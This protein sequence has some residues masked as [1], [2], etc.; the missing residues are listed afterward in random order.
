MFGRMRACC[1]AV[2]ICFMVS[3]GAQA[4]VL[5]FTYE[6]SVEF[7]GGYPPDG[8][9]PWLTATF[10]DG[11]TPGSVNLL[12]E[13][14]NLTDPEFVASWLFNINPDLE[15]YI[16]DLD[17]IEVDR[18]GNFDD[19]T[20][21]TAANTYQANGDGLFDINVEFES[22][23]GGTFNWF[24]AGESLEYRIEGIPSLTAASFDY[25][26]H[27]DGGQGEFPTAAHVGNTGPGD[28]YSG[29][30]TVPEPATLALLALGGL[31]VS[32]RRR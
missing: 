25:L 30:V 21:Y 31:L 3:S 23:T 5:S 17:F 8:A 1:L 14:T 32:R 7:S 18:Y 10:D 15:Q 27:E 11:G 28:G 12:L 19:P 6:L 13:A 9:T 4:A 29:W 24:D 22:A 20:V 16:D 2:A 26:S